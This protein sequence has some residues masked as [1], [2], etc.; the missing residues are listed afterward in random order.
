MQGQTS[1]VPPASV[2]MATLE[3]VR[4]LALWQLLEVPW[5]LWVT[6]WGI[7]LCPPAAQPRLLGLPRVYRAQMGFS[8]LHQPLEVS[9]EAQPWALHLR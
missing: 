8:S 1:S 2:T 5:R 4:K 7:G 3:E 9:P 6:P